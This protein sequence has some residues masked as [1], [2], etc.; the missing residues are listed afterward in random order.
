MALEIF[1]IGLD[2]EMLSPVLT[3]FGGNLFKVLE[4]IEN[5][6]TRTGDLM[7]VGN[8]NANSKVAITTQSSFHPNYTFSKIVLLHTGPDNTLLNQ[9][10][11]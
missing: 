8:G 2:Q 11:S 5:I 4:R 7:I 10:V 6:W 1:F 9:I 3:L